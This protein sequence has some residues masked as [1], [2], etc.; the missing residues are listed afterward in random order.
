MESITRHNIIEAKD[1]NAA[2]EIAQGNPYIASVRIYE[3][4]SM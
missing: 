2:V 1:L 4:S 3:I